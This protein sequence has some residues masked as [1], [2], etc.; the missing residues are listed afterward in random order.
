MAEN[1]DFSHLPLPFLYKGKPKLRGFG[2]SSA[3]TKRNK[4]NR[5]R[6][7]EYLKR[8]SSELSHFWKERRINRLEEALPEIKAGIPILLEIDPSSNID[9][10]RGL[11]FEIVCEIED[12]FII[13]S[14]EDIEFSRLIQKTD[15]F[16]QNISTRCNTPAQVYALCEESDRLKRVLSDDLYAKWNTISPDSIYVVDI[17][18]SCCG[19]IQLPD[20]PNRAAEETDEHYTK[21]EHKW[22]EK[23]NKAYLEWDEIKM[24]REDT[25]ETFVSAY[26]GEIMEMTDGEMEISNPTRE[27]IVSAFWYNFR[28]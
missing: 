10:L 16:I 11:G 12:G 7:G 8:R 18:I 2:S 25:L 9:F 1:K 28:I 21:R 24:Q 23:F 19:N 22:E 15:E 20:R 4:V 17:G 3:Q 5:I 6:H 27:L 13:V 14:S 26:C